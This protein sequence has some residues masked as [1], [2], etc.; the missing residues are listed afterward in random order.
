[1]TVA[2]CVGMGLIGSSWAVAFARHAD[3][4]RVYDPSPEGRANGLAYI[5]RAMSDLGKAGIIADPVAARLRIKLATSLEDAVGDADYVQ[6][7]ATENRVLKR[8]LFANLDKATP[9]GAVIASSTS[10][11]PPSEFMTGHKGSAR[12][13]VAHPLNPPHLVPAVELCPSPETAPETV[14]RAKVFMA[15]CG[16]APL[17]MTAERK[18]FVMNRLQ[19][20][21]VR[22]AWHLVA[23][24][25]CSPQDVDIAVRDGLAHRWSVIGPFETFQL[26]T[27]K[28][29]AQMLTT[30]AETLANIADDL[31]SGFPF[32]KAFGEKLDT[33][34]S[35]PLS[36]DA[37]DAK[38]ARRDAGLL[39]RLTLRKR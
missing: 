1:M 9:A 36:S 6:E 33:A 35:G 27:R 32:D 23:Q 24:G 4:V 15:A 28:G 11:I 12:M 30:Y 37:Y 31:D 16:Q 19:I 34:M 7:S 21:L 8:E 2:A 10:E 5:D 18:G 14:E 29:Y 25:V 20:A 13:V 17:V 3:I 39:Q 22:E 26:T 38:M